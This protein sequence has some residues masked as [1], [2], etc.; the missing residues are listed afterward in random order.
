MTENFE[1]ISTDPMDAWILA[2][3]I[4]FPI[5]LVMS[6]EEVLVFII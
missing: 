2:N 1:D 4:A 3:K 5:I 6:E